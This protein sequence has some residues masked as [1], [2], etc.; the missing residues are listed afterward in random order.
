[1]SLVGAERLARRGEEDEWLLRDV[2]LEIGAG[3]RLAIVGPSGAGKTLL[4][5]LLALLDEPDEGRV[6]WRGEAVADHDVPGYRRR[7]VYLHQRPALV[8]GTVE[9]NL[10]L[11]SSFA[12]T[13]AIDTSRERLLELCDDLGRDA[14]FL[15]SRARE[16]SGGEGQLVAAAR[17][18]LLEPAILLLDEPTASLDAESTRSLETLVDEWFGGRGEER[19]LVWV[20]HDETQAERVADR[21][22]ELREGRVVG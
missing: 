12:G 8:E 1:M 19:A 18:L 9:E 20:S 10:R 17:A 7:V 2:T 22:L 16:L 11:G 4:L 6:L 13:E 15:G 21:R 3:D 14:R 5:R